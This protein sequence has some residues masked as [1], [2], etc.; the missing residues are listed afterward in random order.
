MKSDDLNSHQVLT[1]SDARWH[2]EAPP[3][4]TGNH[5]VNTPFP[6]GVIQTFLSN[7]EPVQ[8]LGAGC[9]SV[10]NLYSLLAPR[11]GMGDDYSYLCKVDDK[12]ALV[13]G[14]DRIVRII[15]KLCTTNNMLVPSAHFCTG[16]DLH[17][18]RW[19]RRD[20]TR[21]ARDLVRIHVL[22]G[23]IRW[24]GSN[25][26]KLALINIIDL[27][28]LEDAMSSDGTGSEECKRKDGRWL[29]DCKCDLW[30]LVRMSM[31]SWEAEIL[32]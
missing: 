6:V 5:W 17:H 12:G 18:S 3:S 24:W 30:G 1:G 13:G 7:L 9:P 15:W 26:D 31:V 4:S 2:I 8:P 19:N 20:K 25:A 22:H 10:V 11:H 27:D 16:R 23:V 32:I 21:V 29:H 14:C 28:P